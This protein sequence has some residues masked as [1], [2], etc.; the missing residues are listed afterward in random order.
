M[1]LK[2]M[3]AL[4]AIAL[5]VAFGAVAPNRQAD[6]VETSKGPLKITP[7]YHGSV[8]LEFGGKIIHVDPWGQADYS[9]CRRPT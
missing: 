6:I 7:L 4:V 9:G 1:K 5:P 8:M 2:T 3:G